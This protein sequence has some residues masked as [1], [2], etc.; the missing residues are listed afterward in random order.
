MN[1]VADELF[2]AG[3]DAGRA[4]RR[5]LDGEQEQ[6]AKDKA[7]LKEMALVLGVS[8][9]AIERV[10]QDCAFRVSFMLFDWDLR[11]G[12]DVSSMIAHAIEYLEKPQ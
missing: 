4:E 3:F 9:W 5:I 6:L 8:R 7:R 11:Q 10:P 1:T 12:D 2:Q